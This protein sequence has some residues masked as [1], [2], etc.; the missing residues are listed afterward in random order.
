MNKSISKNSGSNLTAI[1]TMSINIR[2]KE[3]IYGRTI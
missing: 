3:L 2:A 1:L